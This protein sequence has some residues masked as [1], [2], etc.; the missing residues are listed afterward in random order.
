MINR[1]GILSTI[2]KSAVLGAAMAFPV[3][4][5]AVA[6][7]PSSG[8]GVSLLSMAHPT[9]KNGTLPGGYKVN[10]YLADN[11]SWLFMRGAQN[12]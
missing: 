8:D 7:D 5:L 6:G 4:K 2:F 1:R 11:E 10:P 9:L 3:A 12:D